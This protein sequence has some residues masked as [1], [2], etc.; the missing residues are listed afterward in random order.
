MKLYSKTKPNSSDRFFRLLQSTYQKLIYR[1]I[2]ICATYPLRLI[3]GNKNASCARTR[4]NLGITI[5][6]KVARGRAR[7]VSITDHSRGR[8][9]RTSNISQELEQK[10]GLKTMWSVKILIVNGLF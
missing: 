8:A 1:P 4:G 5:S 2:D 10:G 9:R 3:K 6:E 7:R